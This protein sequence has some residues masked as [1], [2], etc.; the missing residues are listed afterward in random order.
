MPITYDADE[1]SGLLGFGKDGVIASSAW[2]NIHHAEA[3][4]VIEWRGTRTGSTF[5]PFAAIV[6]LRVTK[7]LS[8]SGPR[9]TVLGI[10]RVEGTRSCI[11][12]TVEGD[13][14]EANSRAR[15]VADAKARSHRC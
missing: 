13:S 1:H 9:R 15:V 12:A 2:L 4:G 14:A 10:Y 7:N 11:V 8:I 6:R 5:V 3:G